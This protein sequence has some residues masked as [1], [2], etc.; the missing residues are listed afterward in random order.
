MHRRC[1]HHA[2][3]WPCTPALLLAGACVRASDTVTTLEENKEIVRRI[4]REGV[5]TGNLDVFREPPALMSWQHRVA[6]SAR[7]AG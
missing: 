7:A 5:D 3:L 2:T 6:A 4:V 1:V